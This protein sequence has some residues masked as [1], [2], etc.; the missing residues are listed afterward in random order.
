MSSE[1]VNE[2]IEVMLNKYLISSAWPTPRLNA[3]PR[4]KGKVFPTCNS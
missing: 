1:V 2:G 4:L 3:Y